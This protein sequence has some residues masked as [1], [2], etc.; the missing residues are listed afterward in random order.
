MGETVTTEIT[1]FTKSDGPLTKRIALTDSGT[2][3]SDGGACLMSRGEA[4]RAEIADVGELAA[5]IGGLES[6]QAIALGRLRVG[7]PERVEIVT[8]ARMNGA[9]SNIIARTGDDIVYKKGHP[10]FVL[11][12]YDTK[13]MPGEVAAEIE[14]HGGFWPSLLTVLPALKDVARITRASTSAGLSRTDTGEKLAGSNGLHVYLA[15]R[16]G[17]DAE[18]F[19]KA[20]HDR[21]WL[22]GLGWMMTGAGGQLLERSVIDRMVGAPERLVFEGAPVLVP[23][24]QQDRESRRPVPVAGDALNTTAACPPLTIAEKAKIEELRT[25]EAHRLAPESARVR[26]AYVERRAED[27]SA[28]T[29]MSLPAARRVVESQCSGVLLPDVVLPFD[30][31]ELAGC[32]V[33]DVLADPD[34]FVGLTLADPV[35]GVG[36]GACVA[37]I[38]RRPDGTPW[39]HSFA[40]GR[41]VYELKY[42]AAAIRK[43]IERAAKDEVIETFVA[44]VVV[45]DLNDVEETE[46]RA[47]VVKLSGASA[48]SVK[49]TLKAAQK[50]HDT[51]HAQQEHKRRIAQRADPRPRIETTHHGC[52]S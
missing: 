10:A 22:A 13:G 30:N 45:A 12:D 49:S 6:N 11:L 40:H 43:A 38:M 2:A 35:E 52:P 44:L 4:R 19:L 25:K 36:Y 46:L 39:V 32:T 7:L 47:L 37:K 26:A 33:G 3:K 34:A 5:L 8:K 50:K 51:E 28:R 15:V 42:D 17:A 14:R 9:A 41:A 21:C 23:P 18:R 24:L 48:Q 16:D 1:V 27:V 20:L 29:G 31:G